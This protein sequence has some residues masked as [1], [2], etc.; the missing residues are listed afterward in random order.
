MASDS[1]TQSSFAVEADYDET[2]L[3]HYQTQF[4]IWIGQPMRILWNDYRGRTGIII[5]AL[6]V[7]M[8][9]VGTLVVPT[10]TTNQGEGLIVPFTNPRFPLGTDG[11][12]QDLLG[13]MVHATPD[14]FAMMLAGALFGNLLG[15]TLGMIAGYMGGNIDKVIMTFTD[16]IGSIP[17]LPL[18]IILA[19]LIEPTNPF[20]IGIIVNIQGWAGGS[21][22][23]RAQVFPVRKNEY[24][25][26]SEALGEPVSN[27]LVKDI[28]PN[29]LPL[30]FIGFMGGMT[31]VIHASVALYFLG[32]LPFE[33]NNWGIVLNYA[34][35]SSG[36]WNLSA[37]HWLLVPSVTIVGLTF[38]CVMVAQSADQV[39][40]PRVRARHEARNV[41][42]EGD[43]DLEVV[44]SET[45]AV[46]A[47]RGMQ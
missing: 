43:D 40:N 1:E 44:D 42:K 25:E 13:L 3:D 26:A 46:E 36:F 16:S 7:L 8:G 15:V 9:T 45:V 18:I 35:Y 19:A 24:V 17:G 27:I 22:G 12:G 30:V 47:G 31:T 11:L 41:S 33:A 14:M 2:L 21:R 28:L 5:I 23:I 20:L 4:D 29:L 39:F 38:A 10:P 6:Y 34:Y 37:A 32:I